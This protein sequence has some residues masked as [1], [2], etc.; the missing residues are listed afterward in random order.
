MAEPFIGEIRPWA[1]NFAPRG[2]AFCDGQLLP[3][4]QNTALFSVIG[5]TYGG[6]GR[7][8]LGLPNLQDRAPMHF[9]RGDG[10]T[11]R[12]LGQVLGTSTVT[13]TEAQMPMH[14]HGLVAQNL[15][16][17][18]TSASGQFLAKSNTEGPRGKVPYSTYAP[19]PAQSQM[20]SVAIGGVGGNLA[21]DNLQPYLTI[22]M[23]IAL[24]GLFPSRS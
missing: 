11:N 12:S 24:A 22:N 16:A 9:G 17:N 1:L 10:L 3:I 6:D 13:I 21:H 7:S 14:N 4:S 23:C 19:P 18:S 15:D 8:T 5:T 2:W 20:A